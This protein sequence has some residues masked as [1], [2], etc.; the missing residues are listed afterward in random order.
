MVDICCPKKIQYQD[1][2]KIRSALSGSEM[3]SPSLTKLYSIHFTK[4]D[5]LISQYC[6][7][8]SVLNKILQ[9]Q[10]QRGEFTDITIHDYLI[11]STL[12]KGVVT[13]FEVLCKLYS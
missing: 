12:T 5:R 4:H 11:P 1:C 9:L 13:T 8:I 7:D 3:R 10:H 2:A 6:I